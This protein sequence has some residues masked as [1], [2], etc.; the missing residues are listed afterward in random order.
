MYK[1]RPGQNK[2]EDHRAR[3]DRVTRKLCRA[4]RRAGRGRKKD[5]SGVE[6]NKAVCSRPQ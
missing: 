4:E 6:E 1:S 3:E 5:H 2:R